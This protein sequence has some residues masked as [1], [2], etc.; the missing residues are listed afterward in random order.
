VIERPLLY[1]SADTD[2]LWPRVSPWG[3]KILKDVKKIVILFSYIVWLSAVKF[4]S[5]DIGS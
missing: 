2:G 4:D 5:G 1:V 3:L